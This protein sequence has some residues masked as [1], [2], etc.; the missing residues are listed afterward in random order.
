MIELEEEYFKFAGT[1]WDIAEIKKHIANNLEDYE[2]FTMDPNGFSSLIGFIGVNE[3]YAMEMGLENRDPIILAEWRKGE[4]IAID[5]WHRIYRAI[6]DGKSTIEYYM[7]SYE[8]QLPFSTNKHKEAK[9]GKSG[10]I[11]R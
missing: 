6:Q 10:Q 4:V 8:E 11:Q 7:M 9:H 1:G 5:G 2:V 3:K